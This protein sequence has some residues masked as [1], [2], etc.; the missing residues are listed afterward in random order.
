MWKTLNL[1]DNLERATW[2]RHQIENFLRHWPF[3][4]GIH[5]WIPR[6]RASGAELC[7]VFF[8]LRLNKRLSK[9]S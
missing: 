2:W 4:R 1:D 6:T 8:D 7:D 9:Q 3:V 5:R